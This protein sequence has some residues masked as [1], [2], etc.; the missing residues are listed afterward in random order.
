MPKRDTLPE[1]LRD[2]RI[3]AGMSQ[4]DLEA[5]AG[6]S[7]RHVSIIE[8]GRRPNLTI[9]VLAKLARALAVSADWL[10]GLTE[11]PKRK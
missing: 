11:N 1:R 8:Q 9:A 4:A 7:L 6:L 10:L 3:S 5:R 2:A